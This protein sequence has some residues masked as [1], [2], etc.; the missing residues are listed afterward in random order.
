MTMPAI[1]PTVVAPVVTPAIPPA[2]QTFTLD[3]VK[4]LIK[5]SVQAALNPIAS[6]IRRFREAGIQ[7][8][9][10]VVNQAEKTIAERIAAVE[11]QGETAKRRLRAAA[12]QEAA[13]SNGVPESRL[14]V[15][16]LAFE[17]EYGSGIQI[18]EV[19]DTVTHMNAVNEVKPLG[20]VVKAF[21]GTSTGEIFRPVVGVP[22]GRGLRSGQQQ[23][24][25]RPSLFE[26]AQNDPVGFA[27]LSQADVA[28]MGAED[29][30]AGR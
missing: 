30:K 22:S 15:F 17:H 29:F 11:K 7:P 23:I 20:E 12:I 18:N 28:R 8:T 19:D 21:L 27:K 5:D 14:P 10:P 2:P 13:S 9:T 3:E 24:A 6:D 16:K 1:T 4:V 25:A 26:M